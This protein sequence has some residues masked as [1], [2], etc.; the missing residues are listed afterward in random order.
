LGKTAFSPL[1]AFSVYNA[2]VFM[3]DYYIV[4]PEGDVQETA[5]KQSQ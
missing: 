5:G 1:S 2:G 4:F 3:N